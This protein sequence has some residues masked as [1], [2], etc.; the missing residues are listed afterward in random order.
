MYDDDKGQVKNV[1]TVR[2]DDQMVGMIEYLKGRT[3][4]NKTAIIRLSIANFYQQEKSKDHYL[5]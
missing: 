5:E 1:F 2:F 4:L 3:M